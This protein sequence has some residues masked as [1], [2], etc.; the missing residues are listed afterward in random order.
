[1]KK[2][3]SLKY[4]FSIMLLIALLLCFS[5]VASADEYE[6]QNDITNT[7]SSAIYDQASESEPEE[8]TITEKLELSE[9]R[10]F[11]DVVVM[12]DGY[13]S[14][15]FKVD[16][17]SLTDQEITVTSEDE[18]ILRVP[19]GW[20]SLNAYASFSSDEIYYTFVMAEGIST[21]QTALIIRMG[22]KELRVPVIVLPFYVEMLNEP[23]QVGLDKQKIVWKPEPGADGY[24]IK[25]SEFKGEGEDEY[26]DFDDYKTIKT[27]S[28]RDSSSAV[29]DSQWDEKGYYSVDAY[30]EYDGKIYSNQYSVGSAQ[31]Y[32]TKRKHI[33]LKSVKKISSDTFEI[34]WK[35]SDEGVKFELYRSNYEN[36]K[37]K[38][39][40]TYDAKNAASDG[41]IRVTDKVKAGRTYYY[42][43]VTMMGNKK[44][45]SYDTIAAMI[46]KNYKTT[47]KITGKAMTTGIEY[48]QYMEGSTIKVVDVI[49]PAKLKV[50]SF[51]KK[52]KLKSKK[53]VNIG[54]QTSCDIVGGI[55]H[56]PDGY[57]YVAVGYYNPKESRTKTVIKVVK[58]DKN[59]KR[60][61]TASIKANVSN[62]FEGIVEPFR[63]GTVAFDMLGNKLYVFTARTMFVH[64][65]GLNHQSNIAFEIN[66]KTMKAKER[67]ISYCSHSFN[68]FVRFK[69]GSIYLADHGDAYPRGIKVSRADNYGQ[70]DET[71]DS[72]VPFVFLGRI[73]D[74]ATGAYLNGFEVSSKNLIVAGIAQP[75]N[76]KIKGVTG[77]DYYKRNLFV[78]LT[79]RTTGESKVKWLTKYDPNGKK[80][81]LGVWMKKL[82]DDRFAIIYAVGSIGSDKESLYYM[83]ID[84]NGKK[85]CKKYLKGIK[86]PI[87][88]DL[89]LKDG[90]IWWITN[91]PDEKTPIYN[92][93]WTISY[94]TIKGKAVFYGV[95]AVWE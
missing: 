33:S 7:D 61:K 1:M 14:T 8:P 60:V 21:G 69:D 11:D 34:S 68:Q 9:D 23:E 43:L 31:F 62:S 32:E 50:Y 71:T 80:E 73:G 54:K 10:D 67:N 81:V 4:I 72:S 75:H 85:L 15:S 63:A 92:N 94:K 91:K 66:T 30:I 24:I 51:D 17:V 44:A 36:N 27:V 26:I 45:K 18:S 35:G 56:G 53:T 5:G 13:S 49:N 20:E 37:Y 28:G 52:M 46:P 90:R 58:Y 86:R 70:A 16:Y 25:R 22:D 38:L 88:R 65:D 29:I 55:Y 41:L 48:Y 77:F 87:T 64:E 57:N 74:N 76:F 6:D 3:H 39:I 59:W 2:D 84:G 12:G 19:E 89:I 93:D 47:K 79:D 95:P 42:K 83:A 82:S 78:T 40:G